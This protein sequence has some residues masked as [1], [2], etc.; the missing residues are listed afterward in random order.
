[1]GTELD[2]NY[3]NVE[4]KGL[5]AISKTLARAKDGMSMQ[6]K[7][8]MAIY[9]S[10]IEWKNSNNA[11]EIWID[12]SEIMEKLGSKIDST[13]QSAYLRKLSYN[14]VHHSELHFDG[15]DKNEWEDMPL[16]TRRKSTKNQLMIEIYHGA[17]K[18]IEELNCEYITLFLNDILQFDSNTDGIRAYILYEY[19][20]LHSDTR[21]I[22]TRLISTK[23]FKEMFD[24]P[25]DGKGSYMR[26]NGGFDRT[27]FEKKVIDPVLSM[28]AKCEHVVL[29]NYGIGKDGKPILY[30]KIKKNGMVQ[31]YEISYNINKY[32]VKIKRETIIDVQ[33][34]P[35]V[36]KVAQD[37]I[38]SKKSGTDRKKSKNQFNN[39][40]QRNYDMN[41]L[42]KVFLGDCHG[43]DDEAA[44]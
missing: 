40:E 11:L 19:L 10:K 20:R 7:K 26:E 41:E 3:E 44:R 17:R 22:N 28:L 16:F 25:K 9:L 14:M 27:N 18:L 33:A 30:N 36:L 6:E 21:I 39:F 13:D 37:I 31:G 32:P 34:K 35:D 24:I 23:D 5:I 8:L 4:N 29:H 12:K 42:E 1:M 2:K 15:N 38:T 43:K